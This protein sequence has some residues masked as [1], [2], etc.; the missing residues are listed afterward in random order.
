MG[1]AQRTERTLYPDRWSGGRALEAGQYRCPPSAHEW[2]IFS[3]H[4]AFFHNS[5]I[6]A[7]LRALTTEI[8]ASPQQN[9]E[10]AR[11]ED[12]LRS[13]HLRKHRPGCAIHS[14]IRPGA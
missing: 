8:Q 6:G 1:V 3:E 10:E 14:H 2:A 5:A 11:H 9:Y 4:A 13:N 12:V 7:R